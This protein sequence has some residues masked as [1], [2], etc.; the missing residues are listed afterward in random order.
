MATSVE[1]YRDGLPSPSLAARDVSHVLG[2]SRSALWVYFTPLP[3]SGFD[4]SGGFPPSQWY[5]LIG[6]PC[7]LVGWPGS[8]AH[9]CRCAPASLSPPSGLC[10]ASEFVMTSPVLPDVAIR[11][12]LGLSPPPG[13]LSP[14]RPEC[15][16]TRV[17]PGLGFR[18]ALGV[19]PFWSS[20]CLFRDCQPARGSLPATPRAPGRVLFSF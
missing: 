14:D 3:L 9:R 5:H 19:L 10:P 13:F 15:L 20:A 2:D 4:P 18:C 17:H 1:R 6:G 11:S 8:P 16:H 12:P 7:P